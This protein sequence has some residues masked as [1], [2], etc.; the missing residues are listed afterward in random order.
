MRD[1]ATGS[2]VARFIAIALLL[3]A[4]DRHPYGYYQ[5][6]RWVTCAAGVYAALT[7]Y[8]LQKTAWVWVLA[9][10]AVLFNPVIPV[11]LSRDTWQTVDVVA[12]GVF[13]VSVFM[14]RENISAHRE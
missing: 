3:W 4:L 2:V 7:A 6:L 13:L 11:H 14:V 8:S 9:I 1:Y 5:I 12:A 10:V